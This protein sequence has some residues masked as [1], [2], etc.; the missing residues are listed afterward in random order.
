MTNKLKL[1]LYS[2]VL[3]FTLG[4][5]GND[6]EKS[7]NDTR[8][9]LNVDA[10]IVSENEFSSELLTTADLLPNEQVE[11]K[12]PISG[13]VLAIN[14]KEGTTVK[15]GQSIIRL[16]DRSWKAQLIGLDAELKNA[17]RDLKRKQALIDV[18]GSS[19]EEVDIATTK[20]ENLKAQIQQ[21]KV[22]ID[23]ANVKAPFSGVLG[24]RNFS[25]GAYLSAGT[26]ITT[27][28]QTG[29]IKVDYTL[30]A[31]HQKSIKVG[32]KIEVVVNRDTLTADVYA[33]NP[34]IDLDSRTIN[35]RAFLNSNDSVSVLPGTYAEVIIPT[36]YTNEALLVPTQAIVPEI[37]DQT[38]YVYEKGKAIKKQ[39]FL[40]D[41]TADRVHVTK[42][43][44][45]GDTIITTGLLQVKDGQSVNLQSINH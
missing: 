28:T 1:K 6:A 3:I 29:K 26:S 5:C 20:I 43:I 19:D 38:I 23:L 45:S 13:Q 7:G 25:L 16:D 12:A 39:V 2:A 36:D 9:N 17:E 42:G 8:P 41:R 44:E 10:F 34:V 32:S 33:I 4:S 30:P 14:F 24:M 31:S 40:G 22:N 15:K 27:L 11:L 37:N 18:G 21:L 35:V